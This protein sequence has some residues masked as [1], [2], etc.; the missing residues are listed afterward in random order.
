MSLAPLGVGILPRFAPPDPDSCCACSGLPTAGV[1]APLLRKGLDWLCFCIPLRGMSLAPLG[2]GI[3]PRFAPPDPDSCCACS[4]LPTAGVSAPLLRKGLDWLCFCIPLRGMSL[5]PLGVGILPRFAPPDP[6]SCCAC[7]GLPTAGVSAPLLRKGLD[8][9]CF[10]IPLRGMSLA[11]LGVGI[12]PRFAPPDP[13]SCCACS[14][15]PTAGVSAPLLR[16]GLDWRAEIVPEICV[17]S[18]PP[19]AGLCLRTPSAPPGPVRF[20]A[21]HDTIRNHHTK[22]KGTAGPGRFVS[23]PKDGGSG[24]SQTS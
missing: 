20:G 8:W 18:Q 9:L 3:L 13:D 5:A 11:P 24:G 1:S 7:S 16:K 23:E 21:K 14:G 19:A 6:D 12:L 2:V 15:L 17:G 4:G 10:C 22:P